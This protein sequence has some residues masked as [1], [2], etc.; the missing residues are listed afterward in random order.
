MTSLWTIFGGRNP[1]EN[2]FHYLCSIEPDGCYKWRG[3]KEEFDEIEQEL[4]EH[5]A[6]EIEADHITTHYGTICSSGEC[7]HEEDAA[8]VRG[9]K[10][11]N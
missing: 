6:L 10:Y 8:I 1:E 2:E 5:I 9:K 3:W 7:S 4:R 11:D